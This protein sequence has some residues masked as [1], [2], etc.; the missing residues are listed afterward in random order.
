MKL[1]LV[2]ELKAPVSLLEKFLMIQGHNA[3][4]YNILQA[5]QQNLDSCMQQRQPLTQYAVVTSLLQ[6]YCTISVDLEH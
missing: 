5:V 2:P 1:N 3:A 6:F 4:Y